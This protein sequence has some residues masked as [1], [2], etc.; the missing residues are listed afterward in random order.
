MEEIS[1][2]NRKEKKH[3]IGGMFE[4]RQKKPAKKVIEEKHDRIIFNSLTFSEY[5]FHSVCLSRQDK[6]IVL[7]FF[8]P[9]FYKF[10]LYGLVKD[11]FWSSV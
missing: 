5:I 9:A 10:C 7:A 11:R 4:I 3:E 6:S 8:A 1:V 2:A